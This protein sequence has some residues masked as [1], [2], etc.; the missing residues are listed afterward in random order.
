MERDLQFVFSYRLQKHID[1]Y[2]FRI[3]IRP[4][5]RNT[6]NNTIICITGLCFICF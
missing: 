2:S 5:M 6:D 3:E 1:M 4:R